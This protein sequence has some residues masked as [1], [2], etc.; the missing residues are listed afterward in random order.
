MSKSS[1]QAR[2][3]RQSEERREAAR[4]KFDA[5]P[6]VRKLV[7]SGQ[8]VPERAA[9]A[10]PPPV[11]GMELDHASYVARLQSL[12]IGAMG[13]DLNLEPHESPLQPPRK[14]IDPAVRARVERERAEA[15]ARRHAYVESLPKIDGRKATPEQV[16]DRMRA[17]GM[18]DVDSRDFLPLAPAAPEGSAAIAKVSSEQAR[19]EVMRHARERVSN[20]MISASVAGRALDATKLSEIEYGE[21]L[22][23]RGIGGGDWSAG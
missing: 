18:R 20:A 13:G 2:R 22:K 11:N 9:S 15:V 6:W 17:L 7:G 10:E 1:Q 14:P 4:Q 5:Q 16:A 19:Q 23:L 12:G 8:V 3:A 21:Y